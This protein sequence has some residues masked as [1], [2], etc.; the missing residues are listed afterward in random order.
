MSGEDM[1]MNVNFGED[2][3]EMSGLEAAPGEGA[4]SQPAGG[5][6]QHEVLQ[7]VAQ[8]R[9][10]PHP[11]LSSLAFGP[12]PQAGTPERGEPLCAN[13]DNDCL[14]PALDTSGAGS[15]GQNEIIPFDSQFSRQSSQ[16]LVCVTEGEYVPAFSLQGCLMSD[17]IYREFVRKATQG[18]NQGGQL[19]PYDPDFGDQ[20][21]SAASVPLGGTPPTFSILR[22]LTFRAPT[23]PLGLMSP[24]RRGVTLLTF[25]TK[26][27][28]LP[29][30]V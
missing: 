27:N 28:R 18:G 9:L 15:G 3:V 1:N 23:P 5:L 29:L 16:Q 17:P 7:P 14:L 20:H 30:V 13:A 22:T 8:P 12:L 11:A 21:L 25:S 6:A 26:D 19:V 2:G 4:A 24:P 10:R